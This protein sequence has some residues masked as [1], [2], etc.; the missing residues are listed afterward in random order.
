[1]L[2][3]EFASMSALHDTMPDLARK[4]Y[5]WGTYASDPDTHFFVCAF[6]EMTGDIPD[7]QTFPAKVAELHMKATA[8]NG[9]YGFH[10]QIYLGRESKV[11]T[12]IES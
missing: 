1:M 8:P 6:H 5:G 9:K 12:Y 7:V 3:G 4:P 11:I 2:S 10:V